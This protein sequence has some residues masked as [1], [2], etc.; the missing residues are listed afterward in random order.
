MTVERL[1]SIACRTRDYQIK[2]KDLHETVRSGGTTIK[3][4]LAFTCSIKVYYIEAIGFSF[5]SNFLK[6]LREFL[7]PKTARTKAETTN[8]SNLG[9]IENYPDPLQENIN[10]V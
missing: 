1:N 3:Y 6:E 2:T 5:A 4:F 8:K 7:W 10:C 9:Q